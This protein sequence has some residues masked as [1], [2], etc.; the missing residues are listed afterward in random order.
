VKNVAQNVAQPNFVENNT[1]T[2]SYPQTLGY[3]CNF[4]KTNASKLFGQSGHPVGDRRSSDFLS[5]KKSFVS[6]RGKGGVAFHK[7]QTLVPWEGQQEEAFALR[8]SKALRH[9]S[10]RKE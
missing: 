4:R 10:L 3:F 8:L 5:T 7:V 9:K 1:Q 6:Q 2:N